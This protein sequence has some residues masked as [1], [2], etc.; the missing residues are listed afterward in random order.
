MN[1]ITFLCG[2]SLDL[3]HRY[4]FENYILKM[5]ITFPRDQRV[6]SLTSPRWQQ[7]PDND[8]GNI[9]FMETFYIN[10]TSFNA[11]VWG[12]IIDKSPLTSIKAWCQTG[13]HTLSKAMVTLSM[14]LFHDNF[15][16]NDAFHNF[17][18]FTNSIITRSVTWP[19]DM[20]IYIYCY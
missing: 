19:T 3:N 17:W 10:I 11:A 13:D 2:N 6:N 5:A 16:Q 14:S 4:A 1:L 7:H 8:F 15:R 18:K 20:Q 9:L 12:H